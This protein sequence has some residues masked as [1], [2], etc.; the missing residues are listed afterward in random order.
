MQSVLAFIGV[1]CQL[2]CH[3]CTAILRRV[4]L[5]LLS[6]PQVTGGSLEESKA[7]LALAETD[8]ESDPLN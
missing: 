6:S 1:A 7:A 2:L 5:C 3:S 4:P 8:G